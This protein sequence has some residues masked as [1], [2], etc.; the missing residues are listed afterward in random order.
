ML[1]L[2]QKIAFAHELHFFALKIDAQHIAIEECGV[3]RPASL[4]HGMV[5]A[6]GAPYGNVVESSLGV[7]L[8]FFHAIT[9]HIAHGVDDKRALILAQVR[10]HLLFR[11]GI[12]LERHVPIQMVRR[13]VEQHGDLGRK[14][15]AARQ[16]ER[17]RLAHIHVGLAVAH[18]LD[19][20]IADVAHGGNALAGALQNM[21][22]KRRRGSFAIGSRHSNPTTICRALAPS[23]FHLGND[24]SR[25]CLR[26]F[27]KTG[28][29]GNARA[30]D[31]HVIGVFE[32]IHVKHHMR[33]K[34]LAARGELERGIVF[35]ASRDGHALHAAAEQ[36]QAIR[37]SGLAAF[38]QTQN[39][40]VAPA[41][42]RGLGSFDDR[43]AHDTIPFHRRLSDHAHDDGLNE[44][45]HEAETGKRA[46][47]DPES[48]DDLRFAPAL[49]L[50]VVVQRRHKE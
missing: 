37:R 19:A 46:R 21:R 29:L 45:Q 23:E 48:N 42:W 32:G 11:L 31:A 38:A 7:V 49:L 33:A 20:R 41:R 35:L 27:V 12:R 17:A 10:I 5:D 47:N 26:I 50:E 34:R 36:I 22:D 6:R 44:E 9:R 15:L 3:F 14:R 13:D 18:G 40:H 28:E 25:S 1:A 16:L 24:L 43:S 8:E 2:N 4:L 39:K 30:H